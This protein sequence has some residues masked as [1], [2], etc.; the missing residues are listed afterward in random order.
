MESLVDGKKEHLVKKLEFEPGT[1]S[2][3]RVTNVNVGH[4]S[5]GDSQYKVYDHLI[6]YCLLTHS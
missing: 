5:W 3:F 6:D 4:C 1:L 2:L